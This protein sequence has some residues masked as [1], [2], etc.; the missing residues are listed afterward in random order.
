MRRIEP[1]VAE[2]KR[3]YVDPSARG[4]GVG[5]QILDA[6]EAEARRLGARRIVL[7]TGPRQPEAIALYAR[8][9]F[10]EIPLFG[11]YSIAASATSASAWRKICRAALIACYRREP[12]STV[13][14]RHSANSLTCSPR[15]CRLRQDV[16]A[17]RAR[18]R[19]RRLVTC[20][21]R[22]LC[23]VHIHAFLVA[24][25]AAGGWY[26]TKGPGGKF[27]EFLAAITQSQNGSGQ[28]ATGRILPAES[29]TYPDLSDR[30]SR[31]APMPANYNA[32]SP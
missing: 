24:I 30:S 13:S 28:N 12:P 15:K 16:V 9:G 8:A 19:S 22:G 25:L 11:E 1:G 21:R 14:A 17:L 27:D 2:I 31:R 32:A 4:R 6:L 29:D 18:A 3:M 7:E 26:F 20:P 5:R 23:H 10:A